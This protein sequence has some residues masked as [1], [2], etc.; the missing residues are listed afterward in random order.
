[1]TPRQRT[2]A[3]HALGLPNARMR[4]YRNRFVASYATGGD[5]DQWRRMVDRGLAERS[6]TPMQSGAS[7]RGIASISYLFW[8]TQKGALAALVAG[9]TLDPEDFT[10]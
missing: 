7:N 3:R 2:L 8:L 6:D 9:E 1:M 4:S 10:G 5:Y